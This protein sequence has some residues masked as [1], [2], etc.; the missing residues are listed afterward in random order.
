[1]RRAIILAGSVVVLI[2]GAPAAVSQSPP[3]PPESTEA[4]VFQSEEEALAED[5]RLVAKSQGWTLEEAEAD[6]RA[7]Q[8]VG[9]IAEQIAAERSDVFIGSVLSLQPGLVPA[10]YVKGPADP[11]V[12]NLV[13]ATETEVRV[14]D[15]QPLSFYELEERALQVH[16]S[17]VGLGFRY[18]ATSFDF[19][20]GGQ[21]YA[22]V[23]AGEGQESGPSEI[24]ALLPSSL[25]DRVTVQVSNTPVAG[26]GSSFGGMW[27]R[28]DGAR[29]CTS[30]WSVIDGGGIT[31]VTTAGALY[32]HQRDRTPGSWSA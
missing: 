23:T 30:G 18:V 13:A 28:D 4:A 5:L 31:G 20:Q 8:A 11:F 27:V 22:V 19:V 6:Y 1:M 2:L 3:D 10:V 17:L 24:V 29:E 9:A 21:I 26:P 25:R 7:A 32:G 16:Q 15:D 12:L 14:I